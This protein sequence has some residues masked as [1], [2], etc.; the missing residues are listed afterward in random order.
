MVVT[1]FVLLVT[2]VIHKT[3]PTVLADIDF[4]PEGSHQ[5]CFFADRWA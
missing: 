3:L 5:L 2:V 4:R 1:S